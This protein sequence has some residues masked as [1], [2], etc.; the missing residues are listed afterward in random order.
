MRKG[1]QSV[2]EAALAATLLWLVLFGGYVILG[3]VITVAPAVL[4]R[5]PELQQQSA[6]WFRRLPL[7]AVGIWVIMLAINLVVPVDVCRLCEPG[8]RFPWS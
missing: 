6:R 7:V 1:E 5:H 3:G 8:M 4:L 2:A